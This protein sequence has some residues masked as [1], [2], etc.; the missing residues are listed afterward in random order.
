MIDHV[1][2]DAIGA[3]RDGLED[4]R[5]E[6]L[7]TEESLQSDLLGGDLAW[8]TSYG[9]PGEGEPA[10]MRADVTLGWSVWSQAAY[11]SWITD[12]DFETLPPHISVEVVFRLQNLTAMPDIPAVMAALP[13]VGPRLGDEVL[14]R[15][16]PVVISVL[17]LDGN[18][19]NNAVEATFEG[20]RELQEDAI[21][22]GTKLDQD[23]SDL[24][25]WVAATLVR[26]GDLKL[27]FDPGRS[28]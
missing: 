19:V 15:R 12:G 17:D 4:A 7:A 16:S 28:P 13:E 20:M 27:P 8:E 14:D 18:G 23:F 10:R 26:L 5:L 21:A 3:L 2:F 6:R 24:G 9:L 22:D 11:R 1:F 25:G